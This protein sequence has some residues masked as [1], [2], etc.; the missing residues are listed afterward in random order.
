MTDPATT[1]S[2]PPRRPEPGAAPAAAPQFG[3]GDQLAYQ[4][5]QQKGNQVLWGIFALLLVLAV[6]VF[7]VLPKYVAAPTP[8]N[9]VVEAE[10]AATPASSPAAMSPFEEAQILRQRETAQNALAAL[11]ALQE[12]LEAKDVK[13]WAAEA[14]ADVIDFA[15]Q[16]DTAYREQHF[17]DAAGLYQKSVD[18]L[19]DLNATMEQRYLDLVASGDAALV[20]DAA[21]EAA[22]AFDNALLIQ[23]T[24]AE[25]L[26]GK[27]R[28]AVLNEVLTLLEQG[29]AQHERGELDAAKASYQQALALDSVHREATAAL[30]QVNLDLAQ[31]A[32]AA[33]MSRGYAAL[34]KDDPEAA[35]LAFRDALTMRPDAEEVQ[36][37]LQQAADQISGTRINRYMDAAL[38]FEAKEEWPAALEQWEAALTVDPNLVVADRGKRRTETRL[39]LDVFFTKVIAKPLE[40]VAEDIHAQTR[41]LLIDIQQISN[42]GP[43]LR[44]QVATVEALMAKARVPVT[45]NVQSD[46]LT[47]VTIRRVS[48]LG[49]FTSKSV[50]LLPGEYVAVGVRD[51]YRDAR[52]EFTVNIG[53]QA[54][55]VTV[56]CSEKI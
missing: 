38:V 27:E 6:G 33:A 16:G 10:P 34:Q 18:I 52:V 1:S 32:Y 8:G 55:A 15:T 2:S 13:R 49:L 21:T 9:R 26:T 20:R 4:H 31:R 12:T 28:A 37:A 47:R 22:T 41:Q 42:P 36:V 5:Y 19:Q 30:Q 53:A 56:A 3:L 17:I 40:L 51:G 43:R 50:E 25:A 44:E 24:G 39:E 11:L 23:P 29:R 46:G 45:L 54:P 7:F 35:E 14:Y 48:E